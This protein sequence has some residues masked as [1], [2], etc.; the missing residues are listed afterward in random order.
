[1]I[2]HVIPTISV[3]FVVIVAYIPQNKIENHKQSWKSI[4]KENPLENVRKFKEN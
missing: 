1:M 3:A 4:K 2:H